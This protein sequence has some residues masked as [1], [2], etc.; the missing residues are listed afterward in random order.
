[1][2][3]ETFTYTQITPGF[4]G[5]FNLTQDPN[6]RSFDLN[7]TWSAKITGTEAILN[8]G[9]PDPSAAPFPY[10][11]FVDGVMSLPSMG[12]TTSIT[13]FTGLAD[14]VHNVSIITQ[15]A[16]L[17][18]Y[19]WLTVTDTEILTVT[20]AIPAMNPIVTHIVSD[21]TFVGITTD[22]KV[23]AP[24]NTTP[25]YDQI[26]PATIA[27]GQVIIR[28][29]IDEL[30]VF[31]DYDGVRYSIDGGTPIYVN[32]AATSSDRRLV[33]ISDTLDGAAV[34]TYEIWGETESSHAIS[35]ISPILNSD[36]ATLLSISS[37]RTISQ[38][39]DSITFGSGA[40][41]GQVE[42][43]SYGKD[44]NLSVCKLGVPG[45][46]ITQLT[47]IIPTYFAEQQIPD[48]VLIAIGRNDIVPGTFETDYDAC[49]TAFLNA[50]ATHIICR[51][52]LPGTWNASEIAQVATILDNIVA[53]RGN[54][55]IVHMDTSSWSTASAPDGIHPDAAGY[56]TIAADETPAVEAI[57]NDWFGS[58]VPVLRRRT[59]EL[60]N[61]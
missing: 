26:S 33:K 17:P 30:W 46:T 49:I 35:G 24:A 61:E 20:G 3:V 2:A 38:F 39:G 34:H 41:P 53:T 58:N 8:V 32:F 47:A 37:R 9:S 44:L 54:P 42:C 51:G 15:E 43:W 25:T 45:Q 28:S 60:N 4:A 50:G 22:S 57:L 18:I 29:Q 23:S 27:R 1:M 16:Y 48:V 59:M 12:G 14:T 5:Y 10:R 36:P 56:V 21:P 40:T 31:T 6:R 7:A 11:V 52:Q 55:N 13:L 19:N